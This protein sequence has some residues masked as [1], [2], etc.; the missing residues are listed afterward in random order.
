MVSIRGASGRGRTR[1]RSHELAHDHGGLD[2]YDAGY[3]AAGD[4]V[5]AFDRCGH[6]P[7]LLLGS[8]PVTA[9]VADDLWQYYR[10]AANSTT[11]PDKGSIGAVTR[12]RLI[13]P[14]GAI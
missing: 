1:G 3:A 7:A 11:V 13:G 8:A 2:G 9:S 4:S 10:A 5:A 14:D 6:G 12:G